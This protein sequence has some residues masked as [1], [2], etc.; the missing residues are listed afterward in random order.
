MRRVVY[1]IDQ[2]FDERNF[3]RFGIQAWIDR[4]WNVEVW[5]LTPWAHPQVWHSFTERGHRL[6]EFAGYF[7]V[8]SR[9]DFLR[10]L[11]GPRAIQF[12]AAGLMKPPA[13]HGGP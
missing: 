11:R 12:S 2:P 3:Q 13:A 7:P 9:S 5:D 8:R 6:K 1:L 4:Q 10:R